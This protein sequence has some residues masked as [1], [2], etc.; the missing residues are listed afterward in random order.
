MSANAI[1]RGP[2][3][4][5]LLILLGAR[6]RAAAEIADSDAHCLDGYDTGPNRRR[7]A[8]TWRVRRPQLRRLPR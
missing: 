2:I 7:Q 1:A 4:A 6:G 5:V 3:A 8:G